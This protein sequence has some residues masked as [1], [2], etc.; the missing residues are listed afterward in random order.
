[1]QFVVVTLI[2]QRP[3]RTAPEASAAFGTPTIIH[4]GSALLLS[5][6]V[7]APWQAITAPVI[8]WAGL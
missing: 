1:L 2:A 3:T 4:F 8:L 7:R 6:L 5:T